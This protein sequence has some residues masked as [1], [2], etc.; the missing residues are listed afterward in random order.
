MGVSYHHHKFRFAVKTR[1]LL[2]CL[3]GLVGQG[4]F[5]DQLHLRGNR[6]WAKWLLP[7]S[8]YE[9]QSI[10]CEGLRHKKGCWIVTAFRSWMISHTTAFSMRF[11]NSSGPHPCSPT[12]SC[13]ANFKI[14]VLVEATEHENSLQLKVPYVQE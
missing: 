8:R 2:L 6:H 4:L 1:L 12:L 13:V 10:D 3:H 9:M 14:N 7:S 5:L 11:L